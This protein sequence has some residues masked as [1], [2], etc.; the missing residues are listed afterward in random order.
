MSGY[1]EPAKIFLCLTSV[2]TRL[3]H[4][5]PAADSATRYRYRYHYPRPIL[6]NMFYRLSPAPV[7]WLLIDSDDSYLSEIRASRAAGYY[8][9]SC[10][11]QKSVSVGPTILW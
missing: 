2:G 10:A 4:K 11:L 1:T 8:Y 9:L 6:R 7:L 3:Q 5:S